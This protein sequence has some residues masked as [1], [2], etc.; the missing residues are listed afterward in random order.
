[1]T[2]RNEGIASRERSTRGTIG[3]RMKRDLGAVCETAF[4]KRESIGSGRGLAYVCGG[5][6]RVCMSKWLRY[7]QQY[8]VGWIWR[9]ECGVNGT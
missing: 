7:A 8:G 6:Q 9:G 4:I 1:M 5:M 3:C 2:L